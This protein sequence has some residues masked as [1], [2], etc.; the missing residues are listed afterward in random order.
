MGNP[1]E[2]TTVLRSD[3]VPRR[4]SPFL[5]GVRKGFL[6]SLL[7]AVPA[8]FAFYSE[9]ILSMANPIDPFTL[10]RT[11]IPI[12]GSLRISACMQAI[13]AAALYIVLPWAG[14]A[15]C[16]SHVR[17]KRQLRT[18]VVFSDTNEIPERPF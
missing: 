11:R 2:V 14:V 1:Y 18:N 6:W 7:L 3:Q 15:G 16:V 9:S 12:T 10:S 13:T 17:T 4:L 5:I 8:S